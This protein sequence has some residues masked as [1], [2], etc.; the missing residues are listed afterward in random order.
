MSRSIVV[1]GIAVLIFTCASR[2]PGQEKEPPSGKE[3]QAE[4]ARLQEEVKS[5][6]KEVRR[7]DQAILVLTEEVKKVR[8]EA[9]EARNSAEAVKV[10]M[11]K[12]QALLVIKERIIEQFMAAARERKPVNIPIP[13]VKGTITKVDAKAGLVEIDVGGDVGLKKDHYLEVYRLKPRAEYLGRIRLLEVYNHNSV[14]RLE[15]RLAKGQ[16]LQVG[17]SV[18]TRLGK[19]LGKE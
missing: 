7:R 18:T 15:T 19:E 16:A 2:I 5:L 11:A 8:Q 13:L 1:I 14:G 10:R 6:R 3:L 4:V 9:V 12:L 17:D